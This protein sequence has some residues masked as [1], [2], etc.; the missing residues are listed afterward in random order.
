MKLIEPHHLVDIA[1]LALAA[2]ADL[3]TELIYADAGHPLNQTFKTA[4]YTPS[5][6]MWM[7][8]D[9]AKIVIDAARRANDRGYRLVLTDCLRTTDAQARMGDTPIVR[10]NPHWVADGPNRLISPP[11]AG[12]HPRAMAV[13]IYVETLSGQLIDMGTPLDYF[14]TNPADNPAARDYKFPPAIIANRRMLDDWMLGA[15]EKN[16]MKLVL[17][18]SEWWDFRFPADVYEQYAPLSDADLPVHMKMCS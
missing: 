13:D 16:D 17:L 14:S 9:L 5:A 8:H 4:I 12:A 1:A 18:P 11:G 6:K 2:G 15:A 3:R 10:A 7:H